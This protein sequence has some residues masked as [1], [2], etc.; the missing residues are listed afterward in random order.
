MPRDASLHPVDFKPNP[1]FKN[2]KDKNNK[3]KNNKDKKPE[4]YRFLGYHEVR[5]QNLVKKY[6]KWLRGYLSFLS[7]KKHKKQQVEDAVLSQ[8]ARQVEVADYKFLEI[9]IKLEEEQKSEVP[10]VGFWGMSVLGELAQI[11]RQKRAYQDIVSNKNCANPYLADFLFDISRARQPRTLKS[12]DT[13]FNTDL[14]EKQ[15]LAVQKMLGARDIALVQGPPG[16]GKTTVIAEA[17]L[18]FVQRGQSVLL[19]S[20]SHEAIDNALERLPNHLSLK[21]IRLNKD[22]KRIKDS[23]YAEEDSLRRYYS[24]SKDYAQEIL[25][26]PQEMQKQ[27]DILEE[28]LKGVGYIQEHLE[29]TATKLNTLNTEI[30]EKKAIRDQEL[31]AYEVALEAY[32][33]ELELIKAW[34]SLQEFLYVRRL[35]VM[36]MERLPSSV[37]NLVKHLLVLHERCALK[38]PFDS[39]D[40]DRSS[41]ENK[42]Y[43]LKFLYQ[44]HQQLLK[45]QDQ[46]QQDMLFLSQLQAENLQD[47]Q[48][49]VQID[50]IEQELKQIEQ[51]MEAGEDLN[52]R[53]RELR[54]QRA[55]LKNKHTA[56]N[57]ECYAIFKDHENVCAPIESILQ[58]RNLANLLQQRLKHLS[59][60]NSKI[61]DC[62]KAVV[63]E[64]QTRHI[65]AE[66]LYNDS[67]QQEIQVLQEQQQVQQKFREQ[68]EKQATE[69]LQK[70]QELLNLENSELNLDEAQNKL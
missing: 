53:W 23:P 69:C 31:Q 40:F 13:W 65:P 8:Q 68:K 34:Q 12:I 58:A 39:F 33:K 28:W 46:I 66:P 43:V 11:K 55:E 70:L 21:V 4:S 61:Q 51:A 64:I 19:S 22:K 32:R 27:V 67:L 59:E 52:Q 48:A 41:H 7:Q 54:N 35:D 29:S 20:Q 63:R 30:S 14:N 47:T 1:D 36:D 17:I 62:I 57:H 10:G 44:N 38:R 15:R 56:L 24:A 49:K 3:D 26:S 16:T 9:Q 6:A 2:N 50:Q 18:Q 25:N 60:S 42:I 37:E 45:F 5:N